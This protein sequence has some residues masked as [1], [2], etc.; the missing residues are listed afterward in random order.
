M[1]NN[2]SRFNCKV[3]IIQLI[4]FLLCI[5]DEVECCSVFDR[6]PRIEILCFGSNGAAGCL[7]E[8][9]QFNQWSA[10]RG[11]NK[12]LASES[13]NNNCYSTLSNIMQIQKNV[14][15]RS[16]SRTLAPCNYRK[17]SNYASYHHHG[18]LYSRTVSNQ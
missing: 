18:D 9:R 16:G 15:V 12:I 17:V 11:N 14:R 2:V 8:L 1:S 6:S 13:K 7:T 3:L 5:L 10:T 4:T